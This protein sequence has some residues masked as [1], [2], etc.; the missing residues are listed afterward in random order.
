MHGASGWI[1]IAEA[2]I[3]FPE[4]FVVDAKE[5]KLR[6]V[7]CGTNEILQAPVKPTAIGDFCK[8]GSDDQADDDERR[9]PDYGG[10]FP[11]PP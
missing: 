10:V 3:E 7:C 11:P 4:R 1:D 5:R 6:I 9:R 8:S 2:L